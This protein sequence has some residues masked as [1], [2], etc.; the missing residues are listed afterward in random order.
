MFIVLIIT[1]V[2]RGLEIVQHQQ[3]KEKAFITQIIIVLELELFVM[4]KL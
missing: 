2:I 4:E 1:G 3:Q